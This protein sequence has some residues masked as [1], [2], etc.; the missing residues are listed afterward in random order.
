MSKKVLLFFPPNNMDKI[1]GRG[2]HFITPGEPFGIMYISSFLK[3]K[4]VDLELVDAFALGWGAKEIIDLIREKEPLLVGF[5][6]LTSGAPI[7]YQLGKEIKAKFPQTKVVLGNRHAT[8]FAG[9]F[10]QEGCADFIIRD[11][12]E[13]TMLELYQALSGGG[14]LENILGLSWKRDGVIVHNPD[15]PFT[16]EL[17]IFPLPDRDSVPLDKYRLQFYWG[18]K[19]SSKYYKGMMTSRGCPNQCTYCNVHKDK[20]VRYHSVNRVMEEIGLLVN[21]YKAQ[22]IFFL[23]SLFISKRERVMEICDRI[24]AEKLKFEWNCEGHVNF[25][26]KDLLKKMK[27]AGCHMIA[28]GIESGVQ[29]LLHNVKKYQSLE[30]IRE[31]VRYTKEAGI[32][33]VGL[34]MLGL[35]GET[36]ELSLRTIDFAKSLPLDFAQFA[37]TVPY[38]GTELYYEQVKRGKVDPY[39]W[40]RFSQYVSFTDNMP[41]YVPD[42]MTG[43]EL[44]ALQLR[45]I[46]EFYL[47]PKVIFNQL[48]KARLNS[49]PDYLRSA[50]AVLFK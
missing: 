17:D 37:I 2:K 38:P 6:C 20:K 14:A 16:E 5:S 36:K 47:R 46:K 27:Q 32:K 21:K 24:V 15:R 7:V 13:I 29:E 8:V 11:E 48:L 40:T 1:V 23:D 3:S 4:G 39:A 50:K 42:G 26:T 49:L 43:E 33:P 18:P 30:K 45:A 31:V 19:S 44:K 25:I 9:Y 41:I 34:F 35:P 28:F 10:L 12:G 22:Y